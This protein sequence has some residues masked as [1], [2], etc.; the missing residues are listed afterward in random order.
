MA[1]LLSRDSSGEH[2]TAGVRKRY[3]VA[4]ETTCAGAFPAPFPM[5][6]IVGAGADGAAGVF[7]MTGEAFWLGAG[8]DAHG[9]PNRPS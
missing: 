6:M 5:M 9:G 7:T 3:G 2:V 4:G 1:G 8:A